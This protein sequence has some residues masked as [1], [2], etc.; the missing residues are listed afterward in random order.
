LAAALPALGRDADGG[1]HD[2]LEHLF[3]TFLEEDLASAV[4]RFDF[5]GSTYGPSPYV[6]S[7]LTG[8]Y[9]QAQ[10]QHRRGC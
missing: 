10:Y 7:Q 8:A 4:Q 3:D 2:K 6:V 9:N 5:G 1:S